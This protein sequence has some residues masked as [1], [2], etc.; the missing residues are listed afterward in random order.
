MP[1][2]AVELSSFPI[3][4]ILGTILPNLHAAVSASGYK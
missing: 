1:S 2:V 4:G 3:A